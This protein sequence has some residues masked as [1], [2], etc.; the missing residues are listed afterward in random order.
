[1]ALPAGDAAVKALQLS[2]TESWHG[3]L[4]RDFNPPC[5]G[6]YPATT[7]SL[8]LERREIRLRQISSFI[9]HN[10]YFSLV[11]Q[12]FPIHQ[13]ALDVAL[14]G[15]GDRYFRGDLGSFAAPVPLHPVDFLLL[16]F[17][18]EVLL[19]PIFDGKHGFI[20]GREPITDAGLKIKLIFFRRR[21]RQPDCF[22]DCP[23]LLRDKLVH[24]PFEPPPRP[25]LCFPA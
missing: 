4:G 7:T 10:S 8:H 19:Q 13:N 21:R 18:D 17:G 14:A 11:S 15:F 6:I 24:R 25:V 23:G 16:C 12:R 20:A 9:I 22:C 3:R 1:M 2:L 5:A